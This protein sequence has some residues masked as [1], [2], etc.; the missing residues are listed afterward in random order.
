MIGLGVSLEDGTAARHLDLFESM[1]FFFS[2][3]FPE[4]KIGD[5]LVMQY[6]N[7][8]DFDYRS[9]HVLPGMAE[10]LLRYIRCCDPKQDSQPDQ[11]DG[12]G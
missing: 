11:G 1:G 5:V 8:V 7:N 10:T 6:L 9:V 3:V 4:T 2:G 12:S